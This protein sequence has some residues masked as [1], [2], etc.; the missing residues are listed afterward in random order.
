MTL[1]AQATQCYAIETKPLRHLHF[2]SSKLSLYHVQ[3]GHSL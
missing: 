2:L 1:A 3:F